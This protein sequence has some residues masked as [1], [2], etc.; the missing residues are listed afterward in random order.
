M[1]S[2]VLVLALVVI[3]LGV[4]L[5]TY[6]LVWVAMIALAVWLVGF[7]LHLGGG[8]RWYYW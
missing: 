7:R 1:L 5:A 8:H 3:F 4:E 2:L 6:A